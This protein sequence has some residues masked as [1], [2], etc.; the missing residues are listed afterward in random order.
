MWDSVFFDKHNYRPD[1]TAKTFNEVYK[2]LDTTQQRKLIETFKNTNKVSVD[3]SGGIPGV[4]DAK[5]KL[6]TDLSRE[7]STTKESLNK[8]LQEAK[9][10]TQWDGQKFVPKPLSLSRVNLAQ[11]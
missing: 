8:F 10:T 7:G 9:D 2:K 4:F 11:L 6:D 3:I 1:L 5:A